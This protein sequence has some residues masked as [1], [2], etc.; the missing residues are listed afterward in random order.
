MIP[1]TKI[2]IK[3]D[4]IVMQHVIKIK[5]WN[6]NCTKPQNSLWNYKRIKPKRV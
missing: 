5:Q 1:L 6:F 4:H 3:R 2:K